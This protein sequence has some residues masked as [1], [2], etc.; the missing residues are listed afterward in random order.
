VTGDMWKDSFTQAD[1]HFY[2]Q[3]YHDWTPEPTS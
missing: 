3:V 1:L 2:S